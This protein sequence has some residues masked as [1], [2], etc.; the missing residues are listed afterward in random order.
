[1]D[2]SWCIVVQSG[3]RFAQTALLK[4]RGDHTIISKNVSLE[5]TE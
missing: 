1:M 5:Y 4:S 3:A 2:V